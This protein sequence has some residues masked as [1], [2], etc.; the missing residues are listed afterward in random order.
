MTRASRR[1][2]RFLS[3]SIYLLVFGFFSTIGS[4]WVLAHGVDGRALPWVV[5]LSVLGAFAALPTSILAARH[6][7]ADPNRGPVRL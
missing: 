7:R 2:L 5:W 4:L 3:T 6:L 1:H